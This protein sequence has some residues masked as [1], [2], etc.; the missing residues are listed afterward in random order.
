MRTQPNFRIHLVIAVL[1]VLLAVVLR[2]SPAEFGLLALTIG[3]VLSLEA[4]NSALEA[5]CDVASA[6]YHPL[7][8]V[9]KDVSAAAVLL[10]ALSA[11]LVGLAVFAPRLLSLLRS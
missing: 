7:I 3:L 9:A 1:A 4:L 2:V 8:R 5:L 10:G 11:V 6:T